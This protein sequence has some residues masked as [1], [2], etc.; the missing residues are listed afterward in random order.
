MTDER[1][2]FAS[3]PYDDAVA[4]EQ[5][6]GVGG[7][8]LHQPNVG[9]D[10]RVG[11]DGRVA[12]E[13]RRVRVNRHVVANVGVAFHALD[14]IALGIGLKRF[15]AEGDAL[16]EFH[17]RTDGGGFADDDTGGVIDEEVVAEP[18]A[19][20]DVAAGAFMSVFGEEAREQGHPEMVEHMGET[21]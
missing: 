21:L 5:G 17:V 20:V 6:D 16:I 3:R 10:D 13:N 4:F 2:A 12:A 19:R 1:L 15:R 8:G 9:A 11:A 18:G 7:D 14:G